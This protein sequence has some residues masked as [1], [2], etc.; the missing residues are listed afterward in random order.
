MACGPKWLG[1]HAKGAIPFTGLQIMKFKLPKHR[2]AIQNKK[3]QRR[4]R[5]TAEFIRAFEAVMLSGLDWSW[6]HFETTGQVVM[7]PLH[8]LD[9]VTKAYYL[10]VVA[11]ATKS[12]VEEKKIMQRSAVKHL[13]AAP[14]KLPRDF[15]RNQRFW[16]RV[17][18]RS[19]RMSATL[20][21]Q[22]Q[23][24]LSKEFKKIIPALLNNEMTQ[25][26]AKKQVEKA[27][28]TTSARVST[29]FQTESTNYFAQAQVAYFEDDEG[30]IGFLFDSVKDTSRTSICASRHG[31]IYRPNT[32]LLKKNTPACF[33]GFTPVL[34]TNGWK[35]LDTII[36]GDYV[37]THAKRWRKVTKLHRTASGFG[38]LLQI[39]YAVATPNH[40]YLTTSGKFVEA[41]NL[42]NS[43]EGV[44]SV[45]SSLRCLWQGIVGCVL[46][47]KPKILFDVLS[48][49]ATQSFA[50]SRLPSFLGG[51][52]INDK[53]RVC[54][55]LC[56]ESPRRFFPWLRLGASTRNGK[57][58]WP[59]FDAR[60]NRSSHKSQ[61]SGQSAGKSS[62]HEQCRSHTFA[63]LRL[64][65]AKVWTQKG[66]FE[67][68]N[69]EV[70]EDETY[71]A[72]G[73]VVHNCHYNC[74]SDLIP[75][76]DTPSNRRMLADPNRDPTKR[77]VVPL[78]PGWRS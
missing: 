56:P 42:W 66:G 16:K 74:R 5:V 38:H 9:K 8:D 55:G 46:F 33:T 68:F 48:S 13:M 52:Q 54:W 43:E 75:L 34:T 17:F 1:L 58:S 2:A 63:S 69:L 22:Y 67:V 47:Q 45:P 24:K 50:E 29:I 78:P 51:W 49:I 31:L 4:D 77:K 18:K 21:R 62:G 12:C 72:G 32:E 20:R 26:E 28:K 6:N 59:F 70:E 71:V 57:N 53:G 14:P 25:T 27:F 40:P 19:E 7:P 15:F 39:G 44:R 41:F 65:E 73:Y 76:E 35:R 23:K 3:F 61:Q 60:G 37:W 64:A 36:V 30:T 11:Q 10:D